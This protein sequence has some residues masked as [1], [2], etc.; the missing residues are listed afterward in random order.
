MAATQ[1]GTDLKIS[2]GDLSYTGYVA[3]DASLSFPEG[4]EEVIRDADG[5]THT[6]IHMD[7]GQRVSVTFVILSATGSITPPIEG[8]TVTLTPP[9]G[10]ETAYRCVSGE[11][12][13]AAG[14]TRLALELIK[15]GSMT[16]S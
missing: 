16:Y 10:T 9:Q 12:S 8:A 6:I 11:A 5:A 2:F 4:N 14:A 7:P 3:Q 13:F 15:E 1:L